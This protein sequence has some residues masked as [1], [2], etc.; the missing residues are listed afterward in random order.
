MFTIIPGTSRLLAGAKIPRCFLAV[1][2][3]KAFMVYHFEQ[4]EALIVKL[5]ANGYIDEHGA[6]IIR[7][8]LSDTLFYTFGEVLEKLSNYG[9]KMGWGASRHWS[10]RQCEDHDGAL[11][12]VRH[13]K[14]RPDHESVIPL[15]SVWELFVNLAERAR[16]VELNT[17]DAVYLI[18]CAEEMKLPTT[19]DDD[20]SLAP[21]P[22]AR[23][24][25]TSDPSTPPHDPEPSAQ[26][27]FR[28]TPFES[29]GTYTDDDGA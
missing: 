26:L 14:N 9:S 25:L 2:P 20:W 24:S 23:R 13:E 15:R 21:N 10:L 6:R 8:T 5:Q 18:R 28:G 22:G 12:L 17:A 27:S 19:I 1:E 16:L 4:A 3:D 11:H 7:N 29:W